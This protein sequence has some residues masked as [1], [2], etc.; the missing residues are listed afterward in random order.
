MDDYDEYDDEDFEE[1]L[2]EEEEDEE[3]EDE[4][5]EDEEDDEDEQSSFDKLEFELN[6]NIMK[7]KLKACA[8]RIARDNVNK[9]TKEEKD[10]LNEAKSKNYN[11]H[12]KKEV[13]AVEGLLTANRVRT[14]Y[15]AMSA[16]P[17]LV[18]GVLGALLLFLV[19]AVIVVVGSA[20]P[21]LGGKNEDG[22]ASSIMGITGNDFFGARMVYKDDELANTILIED[23]VNYISSGATTAKGISSVTLGGTPYTL[24]I[25][26]NDYIIAEN[27]D[28]KKFNEE[29]F[30]TNYEKLYELVKNKVAMPIYKIDND[31]DFS[32]TSLI[33]CVKGIKYFGFETIETGATETTAKTIS[34]ELITPSMITITNEEGNSVTDALTLSSVETY[35]ETQVE[36]TLNEFHVG[37]VEKLF[38]KDYILT[39]DDKCV[40]NVSA[41]NYVAMIFMPKK[42]VK[43][44]EFSF[45]VSD[46]SLTEFSMSLTNNGNE[47][48]I[49][50]GGENL[51]TNDSP[52]YLY[53]T[54]N[55]LNIETTAFEDI[56]TLNINALAKGVSLFEVAK[57]TNK[58]LYLETKTTE[59]EG[60]VSYL[61]IKQN[62]VVVTLNN[63]E[64][65]MFLEFATSWEA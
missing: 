22:T 2:D 7:S 23:Y 27:F 63:N 13:K 6:K 33:D 28:F 9:L 45:S 17:V 62:G 44:K 55:N 37:R 56:D 30:K 38:V 21:T 29:T 50:N 40:E 20:V 32:G 57:L 11:E 51:G 46:S 14:I 58:D 5:D 41:E 49:D 53:A 54:T 42:N 64:K 36:N 16:S 4:E 65:F 10:L 8:V 19:I 43:F 34:K 1:E 25:N 26:V 59:G 18:Y 15:K 52:S 3:E 48:Q 61:T 31:E 12:L 39:G 24:T 47:I 35:V 60:S